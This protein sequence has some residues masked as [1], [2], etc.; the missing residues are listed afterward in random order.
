MIQIKLHDSGVSPEESYYHFK[1]FDEKEEDC[2]ILFNYDYDLKIHGRFHNLI[3][4]MRYY[5]YFEL[6]LILNQEENEKIKNIKSVI[7]N[8]IGKEE[9]SIKTFENRSIKINS[10][11][12]ILP[13]N[14]FNEIYDKIINVQ[15]F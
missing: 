14:R 4:I 10:F 15:I 13:E 3:E 7:K 11:K 6:T 2:T 8:I 1:A 5:N 12:F 9:D